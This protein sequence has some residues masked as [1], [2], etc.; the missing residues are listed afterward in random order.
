M[1]ITNCGRGV[2]KRE[3]KGIE[4]FKKDLPKQWYGFT[5]LDL[6]LGAGKSREVDFII[7]SDMRIFL[8]DIKDWHGRI[9]SRDG[10]WFLNGSDRDSS[11]VEKVTGIAR[12]ISILLKEALKRRAETKGE[13]VPMVVGLVVLTGQADR[14]GI[15]DLEKAKVLTADELIRTVQDDRKQREAFGNVA[16]QIVS[17]PLTDPFWKNQLARFFNAG[18]NSPFR[19]SHRRFQGYIADDTVKFSH[20][21]DVYREYDAHDEKS[22]NNLGTLRLWDFTKCV[23][24]RFQT[25]E[26]RL[27]IAGR[28]QEVYQW[29]RDRD[30]DL[31]RNLLTPKLDDTDHSVHYWEIYDRRRRMQ[32]LSDFAPVEARS[33]A[34]LDRID[35]ARQML[36]A[37]A[38]VH[39]QDAAHLDLGGHSIWLEVADDGEAFTP[40][41][42]QVSGGAIARRGALSIP[43]KRSVTRGCSGRRPGTETQRCVSD[44]RRRSLFAVRSA[45]GG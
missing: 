10:R 4:R 36:A 28:E 31:E 25:E 5:N 24:G 11:P 32:R 20:P 8:V 44:R 38:G 22:P 41:G 17:R 19:P 2:H 26:G 1:Q 16:P 29:L 30:L 15:A 42:R 45:T 6:V 14:A 33:L 43:F 13:P 3:I 7:V 21:K 27:E 40:F 37:V 34:P 9:E 35:L 23:D 12:E 39:R 18:P